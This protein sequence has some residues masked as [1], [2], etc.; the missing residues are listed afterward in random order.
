MKC[1]MKTL[2]KGGIAIG[3]RTKLSNIQGSF[4]LDPQF[5][6]HQNV[7]KIAIFIYEIVTH[8]L[9]YQ[10]LTKFVDSLK[11]SKR[12]YKRFLFQTELVSVVLCSNGTFYILMTPN[13]LEN[14]WYYTWI[15][16]LYSHISCLQVYKRVE[17]LKRKWNRIYVV[18]WWI[19][20]IKILRTPK[21]LSANDPCQYSQKFRELARNFLLNNYN[22]MTTIIIPYLHIIQ[23]QWAG[24]TLF[25]SFFKIYII[26]KY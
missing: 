10:A 24:W 23:Q 17:P 19:C 9:L 11:L 3:H 26:K 15:R 18:F 2:K 5:Y 20:A 21:C 8:K 14:W 1:S 16:H 7:K 13:C 4:A 6:G 25:T 22:I 12:Q